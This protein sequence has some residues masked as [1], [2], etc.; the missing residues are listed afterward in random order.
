MLY[1]LITGEDYDGLPEDPE[2]RF[3][4]LEAICRNNMNRLVSEDERGEFTDRMYAQYMT[5]V[6]AAAAELGVGELGYPVDSERP[7]VHIDRFLLDA[8][9]IITRIR[10]R[11]SGKA[12]ALSVQLSARNR[13]RIELEI[14]RLRGIIERSEMPPDKRA[15]LLAK[16]DELSKEMT[17]PRVTFGK[18]FAVLAIVAVAVTQGTS[19]L[20]DA[21]DAI[22]TIAS[23]IGEDKEAEEAEIAR[24]GPPPTPKALPA[25]AKPKSSP[26]AFEPAGMDDDI[27]F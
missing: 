5:T 16:L 25:P 24:L 1:E 4:A 22:A 26:P 11:A 18:A 19:F 14:R 7:V 3:V 21:P 2:Q 10:L 9:A 15:R 13:G 6:S 12:K 8:S 27:P 17:S 20:A 23:L